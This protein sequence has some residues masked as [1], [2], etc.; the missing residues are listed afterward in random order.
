MRVATL[1]LT[2]R[3]L[4]STIASTT[5]VTG[6]GDKGARLLSGRRAC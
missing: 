5:T 1:T 4:L 6:K 3:W 2:A